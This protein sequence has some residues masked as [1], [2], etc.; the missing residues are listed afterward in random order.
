MK[1]VN[2]KQVYKILKTLYPEA[3]ISLNYTTPFELAVAVRLSAQCTDKRV[4]LVTNILFKEY[5]TVEDYS[6]ADISE[7]E[8]I[9][10]PAGLFRTKAGNIV[11]MAK[12]ITT[13]YHSNLPHSVEE[14]AKLPGIGKKSANVI[15][16]ELFDDKSG[17]AVDT[18]VKRLTKRIGLTENTSPEK[19]EK[20]L[21]KI[22]SKEQRKDISLLFVLHGRAI[23]KAKNPNCKGCKLN[24]I[25]QSAFTF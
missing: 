21:I 22:F 15:A 7:L 12:I 14:L 10:K 25:C 24:Q 17:I 4:N 8:Q 3:K 20:D 5:K 9:I 18:H 16:N 2:P 11:E 1:K 23:C 13:K 6:S 19:I